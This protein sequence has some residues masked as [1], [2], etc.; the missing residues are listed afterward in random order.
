VSV[1]LLLCE[2]RDQAAKGEVGAAIDSTLLRL[3]LAGRCLVRGEGSKD[4]MRD[5]V[6]GNRRSGIRAAAVTDGD[7]V[8]AWPGS[9]AEPVVS[10]RRWNH[11]FNEADVL[12]GWR[13]PRHEIENYLL[14]PALVETA[15]GQIP[16]NFEEALEEAR[17]QIACYQAARAAL[18]L[19]RPKG[20]MRILSTWGKRLGSGK[21]W[22]PDKS[23]LSEDACRKSIEE[24][25]NEYGERRSI[26]VDEVLQRMDELMPDYQAGGSRYRDYLR[27]YSG[28][29][30]LWQLAGWLRGTS[31]NNPTKFCHELLSEL[32]G[33]VFDPASLFSEWAELQR[34]VDEEVI[35]VGREVPFE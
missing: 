31:H 3:C 22:M 4:S 17:D 11:R 25:I 19:S 2:G 10:L 9:P 13:W 28:K 18:A 23:G 6:L 24:R 12:L 30:L 34:L 5:S 14:D 15:L 21:H 1:A 35:S 26:S 27:A 29:D 32:A 7:F 16:P 33:Q 20:K 8:P